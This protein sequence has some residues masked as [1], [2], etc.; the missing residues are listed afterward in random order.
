[1]L[2]FEL[3]VVNSLLMKFQDSEFFQF[4]SRFADRVR[5]NKDLRNNTFLALV[6]T[7]TTAVVSMISAP[8]LAYLLPREEYGTII[9]I[10]TITGLVVAFSAPGVLN[11]ISFSVARGFEGSLK[12]GTRYRLRV[13][14]RNSLILLPVAGWY[15]Y[16]EN[17]T[18]VA[19][20]LIV[21]CLSLPWAVAFDTGEQYLVGR[22]DFKTMFWRRIIVSVLIALVGILIA[23]IFPHATGVY[24]GKTLATAV[25]IYLIYR[26]LLRTTRNEKQDPEFWEKAKSFNIISILTSIGGFTD[27]LVL[28]KIGDLGILGGFSLALASMTP[29]EIAGKSLIKV[30]Y[31]RLSTP[32]ERKERHLYVIITVVGLISGTVFLILTLPLLQ[33]LVNLIFPKYPEIVYY[34]PLLIV[35]YLFHMASAIPSTYGLFHNFSL[36]SSYNTW[37]NASRILVLAVTVFTFGVWGAIYARLCYAI[38]DYGMFTFLLWK[39]APSVPVFSS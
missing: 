27:K 21:A 20:L 9:Y 1:M 36:W 22:S 24:I 30:F 15:F 17:D 2:Q 5:K 6:S 16:F 4:T 25:L 18:T 13:Y 3:K 8:I 37:R 38:L 29:F 10:G 23:L 32:R 39:E 7:A 26:Y 19:L 31:G 33:Q 35:T 34:L 12:Q 11:A 14:F 28:G